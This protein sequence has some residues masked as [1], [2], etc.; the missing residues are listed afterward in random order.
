MIIKEGKI[1]ESFPVLRELLA[2][3]RL[4]IRQ[5]LQLTTVHAGMPLFRD[6]EACENYLLI[7]EGSAKVQKLSDN[8]QIITLYHLQGGQVCE[9]TT[10]CLLAGKSYPAEAIAESDV[11]AVLLP[12]ILFHEALSL[13]PQFRSFVFSSVDKG[14][15]DL[16]ALVEEVTFGHMDRR[17][18]RRLL[19]AAHSRRR[20]QVTHNIL[21]EEL[22][23]A[24]EVV[25]RLLKEFEGHGWV[26]LHRGWIE[27]TDKN[28]LQDLAEHTAV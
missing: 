11:R 28:S 2:L 10:S 14:M 7:L 1:L 20:I 6:G 13:S 25:S 9:L 23:T 8:G 4:E 3:E 21:A 15:H 24:R 17:L 22:G 5:A 18:A 19:K 26:R 12:K 16:V 27:I